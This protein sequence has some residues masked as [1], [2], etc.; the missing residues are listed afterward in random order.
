MTIAQ[1]L[2]TERPGSRLHIVSEGW[3]LAG[4]SHSPLCM[5]WFLRR[6]DAAY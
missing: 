3:K 1:L 6:L 5:H 2:R 4:K